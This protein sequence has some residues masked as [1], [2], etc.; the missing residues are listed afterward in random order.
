MAFR[1][2]TKGKAMQHVA[3]LLGDEQEDGPDPWELAWQDRSTPWDVFDQRNAVLEIHT[4]KFGVPDNAR[5]LV[6]GCGSGR[7]VI[8]I[9][10]GGKGRVVHGLEISETATAVANSNINLPASRAQVFAAD[11]FQYEPHDGINYDFIFDYTFLCALPLELRP[12]W[13]AKMAGLVKQNTGQ[14]LTY[15]WPL[16][17]DPPA[18]NSGPKEPPMGPPY[19][20]SLYDYAIALVPNGFRLEQAEKCELD[21]DR[22]GIAACWRRSSQ[23]AQDIAGIHKVYSFW[24]RGE[25]NSYNFNAVRE[26]FGGESQGRF[27]MMTVDADVDQAIRDE[28]LDLFE[29]VT[30]HDVDAQQRFETRRQLP[31]AFTLRDEIGERIDVVALSPAPERPRRDQANALVPVAEGVSRRGHHARRRIREPRNRFEDGRASLRA[32]LVPPCN[33]GT[34]RVRRADFTHRPRGEVADPRA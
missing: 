25:E 6:P 27:W 2:E 19:P 1:G 29:R 22:H 17:P 18:D 34:D 9:A 8:E 13:A 3:S 32:G 7:D 33:E 31:A 14:L 12:A 24:F 16:M 5:C 10:E 15:V 20:V 23:N 26:G 30:I 11:F 28:F 4:A 21:Q